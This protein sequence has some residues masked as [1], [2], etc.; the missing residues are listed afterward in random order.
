MNFGNS[1]ISSIIYK[2]LKLQSRKAE[3]IWLWEGSEDGRKYTTLDKYTTK[4]N[5]GCVPTGDTLP[6]SRVTC[7]CQVDK[8]IWIGTEVGI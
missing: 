5:N 8:D 3:T 2:L 6:G 1:N 7:M 4:D